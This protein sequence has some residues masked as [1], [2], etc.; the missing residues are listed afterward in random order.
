MEAPDAYSS[1]TITVTRH[2][3]STPHSDRASV[4]DSQSLSPRDDVIAEIIGKFSSPGQRER[5]R[6]GRATRGP[7]DFFNSRAL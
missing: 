2:L 5:E 1:S 7:L 4:S 6:K 3:L